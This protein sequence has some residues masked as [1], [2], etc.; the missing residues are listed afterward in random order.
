MY[1]ISV[2]IP[3]YNAEEYLKRCLDSVCMQTLSDIEIIC[4]DDCSTDNSWAI[5][6]EYEKKFKNMKLIHLSQNKGESVARN[7]GIEAATGEYLAFVDNDDE[8]DLNFYEKLYERAK[9][10]NADIVKGDEKEFDYSGNIKTITDL[11]ALIKRDKNKAYFVG[12]WW[13]AIYRRGFI[14]KFNIRLPEG[15]ILGGDLLFANLSAINANKIEIVDDVYYYHYLRE[16][17][18]DAKVLSGEKIISVLKIYKMIAENLNSALEAGKIDDVGYNFAYKFIMG[19]FYVALKTYNK[20]YKC[21]CAESIMDLYKI[22]VHKDILI[23]KFIAEDNYAISEYLKKGDIEGLKSYI[24][25]FSLGKKLAANL[26]AKINNNGSLKKIGSDFLVSVIIPIYNVEE[27]IQ[28]CIDCVINQTYENLEIICVNDCSP[29]NSVEIIENY[30]KKDCRIKIFNREKNG[31]LSAARNSGLEIAK[32]E[33]IYFLD[34]D[35][36]IDLDYIEKMVE[37]IKHSQT[38]FVVNLNA[39]AEKNGEFI[40]DLYTREYLKIS[41]NGFLNPKDVADKEPWAVW[42]NLYKKSFIDKFSLR[43]PDG[44]IMEDVFYHYLCYINTDKVYAFEGS[45]YHYT[46]R[47]SSITGSVPDGEIAN[48][49]MGNY[50]YDYLLERGLLDKT[51]LKV[52][53]PIFNVVTSEKKYGIVKSF[54]NKVKADILLKIHR[55]S[56]FELFVIG[57]YIGTVNFDEYKNKY[58][59][60]DIRISYFR[61]KTTG[62]ILETVCQKVSG[63]IV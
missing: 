21:L 10:T 62:K 24:C 30:A 59:M 49:T 35:D 52:F 63:E 5:L 6:K 22:C 40:M 29:D 54:F 3:V 27:Y 36:W 50:I 47:E 51:C 31:G 53:F 7:T 56:E 13:T 17:S 23:Q 41:D 42:I 58:G 38:D 19:G 55:Y 33:Y 12:A 34:S 60:K 32:G 45:C 46:L 44:Y 28:R 18:G 20:A 26:R 61:A 15:Y 2:I 39:K 25:S 14:N 8:I 11:N 48:L 4:V 37:A 9:E 1:K 43:F 57:M 16:N